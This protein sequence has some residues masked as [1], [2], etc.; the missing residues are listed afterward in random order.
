ML[1]N[2]EFVN[3]WTN[4]NNKHKLFHQKGGDGRKYFIT[5]SAGL[6]NLTKTKHFDAVQNQTFIKKAHNH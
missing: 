5:V 6:K 2:V 4:K 1:W 3:G